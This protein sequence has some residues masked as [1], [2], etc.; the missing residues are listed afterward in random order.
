VTPPEGRKGNPRPQGARITERRVSHQ[1][2]CSLVPRTTHAV[3][4]IS[5]LGPH[6]APRRTSGQR[7][8]RVW[9]SSVKWCST[10]V[11]PSKLDYARRVREK[12][13]SPL[14]RSAIFTVIRSTAS[15]PPADCGSRDID[16]AAVVVV[17]TLPPSSVPPGDIRG[18]PL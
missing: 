15:R 8:C 1:R 4:Q 14:P 18:P 9:M 10:Q 13:R 7:Y 5:A 11:A 2:N 6:R 3:L 17:S 16:S 12:R